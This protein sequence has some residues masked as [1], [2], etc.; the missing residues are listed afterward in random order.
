ML[1]DLVIHQEPLL[2]RQCQDQFSIWIGRMTRTLYQMTRSLFSSETLTLF[3]DRTSEL[4][5][6]TSCHIR[7]SDSDNPAHLRTAYLIV[8]TGGVS[9]GGCMFTVTVCG[10]IR[11]VL[12]ARRARGFRGINYFCFCGYSHSSPA[13]RRLPPHDSSGPLRGPFSACCGNMFFLFYCLWIMRL[14]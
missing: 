12:G 8:R 6:E 3:W 13:F 9:A 7:F 1:Y 10:S 2:Q 11:G 4:T 5:S 14:R